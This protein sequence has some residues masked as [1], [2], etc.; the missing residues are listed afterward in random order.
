M[1][2]SSRGG[3]M[4]DSSPRVALVHGEAPAYL[5]GVRDYVG[6]LADALADAG[7]R[8][9]LVPVRPGRGAGWW[10]TVDEA[11]ARV[12]AARPDLVHVQFAPSAYR[13]SHLPGLLLPHRLRGVPLVTTLHEYGNP[14]GGLWPELERRGL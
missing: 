10:S 4:L 5:D 14:P 7:V 11:A 1:S 13:F 9:V 12:A 6:R 8:P 2:H 3:G